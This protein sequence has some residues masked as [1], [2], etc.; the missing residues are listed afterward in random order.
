M[1]DDNKFHWESE[2]ANKNPNLLWRYEGTGY[3]IYNESRI[4]S[5][6][7]S[8]MS[9]H[10]AVCNEGKTGITYLLENYE[11]CKNGNFYLAEIIK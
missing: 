7:N 9:L 11:S 4:I 3:S 6:T 8:V 2:K 1:V 5:I 10:D